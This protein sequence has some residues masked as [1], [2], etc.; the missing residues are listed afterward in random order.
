MPPAS[1]T[2]RRELGRWRQRGL[3]HL[4][5]I[6]PRAVWRLF[7]GSS[8][9]YG[10]PRRWQSWQRYAREHAAAW[11]P[12]FPA[13]SGQFRPPLWP[14]DGQV[15]FQ[16]GRS[17]NWPEQGVA[18]IENARV[19]SNHGWCVAPEDTFLG[20]L[21][22]G[23]NDRASPVYS[24]TVHRAPRRLNGTTLNLCSAHAAVNFCH[25]LIDSV[26]RLALLEPAGISMN[27]IDHIL[28]PKFPGPTARWILSR[29]ELPAGKLI[30]PGPRD[31]FWCEQLLQPSYPGFVASYPPWVVDFYRE[32]FPAPEVSRGRRVYLPRRGVRGIANRAEVETE[33]A[34]WGF[35]VFEP[36]GKTELQRAFAD[37]SHVIGAHGAALANLVFCRP[38]TRVLEL[39]PSDMPHA[40]YYSLCDSGDMPYGLVVGK[41]ERERWTR[42]DLPTQS[43][44]S[45]PLEEL[46]SALAV[47]TS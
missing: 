36:A 5:P 28:L 10:P 14:R 13:R 8:A 15:P 22:F 4:L 9:V 2:F 3:A 12:A 26:G 17:F 32:R 6:V 19:I 35:E 23:G 31:Q 40:Y 11:N 27:A 45:V 46:R 29:I 30:H 43:D 24:L 47:M 44:F 41:S 39:M 16:E 33:I 20:D 42:W 38:G 18:R 34:R 37:V 1:S 7:P 21:C 25:W